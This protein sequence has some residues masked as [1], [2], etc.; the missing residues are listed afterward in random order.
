M[1][2]DGEEN[3]GE[4]GREEIEGREGRIGDRRMGEREGREMGE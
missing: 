4:E 2:K 1:R 3:T